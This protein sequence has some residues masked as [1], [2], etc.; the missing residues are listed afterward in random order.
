M[1][2]PVFDPI[3]LSDKQN[4]V[5]SSELKPLDPAIPRIILRISGYDD[6]KRV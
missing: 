5:S 2:R 1:D 3:S 6:N 4:L